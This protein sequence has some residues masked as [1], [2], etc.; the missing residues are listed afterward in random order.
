M[1]VIFALAH[2]VLCVLA[3]RFGGLLSVAVVATAIYCLMISGYLWILA[4]NHSAKFI[5][6][7][8]RLL[9]QFS[10]LFLVAY[11]GTVWVQTPQV[12]GTMSWIV[13][14]AKI[15][16]AY[17]AVVLGFVLLKRYW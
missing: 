17:C 4:K 7:N 10:V 8:L 16:G 11:L 6:S 14:A 9:G 3:A 13:E 5:S 12:G 2:I 15:S 1:L